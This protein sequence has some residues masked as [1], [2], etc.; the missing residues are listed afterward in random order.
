[1]TALMRLVELDSGKILLDGIDIRS[2]G[3]KKLRS[4]IAVIPQVSSVLLRTIARNLSLSNLRLSCV[5][6]TGPCTV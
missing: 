3:L 6:I 1:M 5:C 4:N 2:V